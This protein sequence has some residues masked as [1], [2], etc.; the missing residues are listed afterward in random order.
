MP[1]IVRKPR[2]QTYNREVVKSKE[3]KD[4]DIPSDIYESSVSSRSS[5]Y[6]DHEETRKANENN[7]QSMIQFQTQMNKIRRSSTQH[8]Y[9]TMDTRS[10]T[11]STSTFGK[12]F[13]DKIPLI[14][15]KNKNR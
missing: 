10:V 14:S 3:E 12:W 6:S 2:R 11:I 15:Y 8:I 4:N 5:F 7:N 1:T 9:K 13:H